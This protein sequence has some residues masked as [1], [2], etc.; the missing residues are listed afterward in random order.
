M[1]A[2][3]GADAYASKVLSAQG[4]SPEPAGTVNPRSLSGVA[5]DGRSLAGLLWTPAAHA[6]IA[7]RNGRTRAEQ[8]AAGR[9]SL[10]MLT[11]TQVADAGRVADGIA[12]AARP[13]T[14]YVR[15]LV[16]DSC[17]R[18][19][20]LAGRF[21]KY[22]T[23]FKRHPQCDCTM[24]PSTEDV[25]GDL[26]T[27]PRIAF[28][29]GRIEGLSEADTRAIRDGADIAQVI[30]A[31]KKNGMY[32]AGGQKF[33]RIGTTRHGLAGIRLKGAPRLMPEQIYR[34]ATSREDAIRLLRLHGY[35]V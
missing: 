21:Y 11:R 33:T 20:I 6:R 16:G 19:A 4:V 17:P 12:I 10:Q 13:R 1:T 27:D 23:G 5:S 35:L 26:T 7:A 31:H 3:K 28:D 25:A 9:A 2:A 14:G 29:A 15:M 8:H 34:D 30:N 18:C 24:I 22:S 32:V